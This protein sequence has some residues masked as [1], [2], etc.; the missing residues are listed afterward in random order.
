MNCTHGQYY[1]L[2]LEDEDV[3]T[4]FTLTDYNTKQDNTKYGAAKADKYD[5]RN[6]YYNV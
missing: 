2:N 5:V 3:V 4:N 1:E 6:N